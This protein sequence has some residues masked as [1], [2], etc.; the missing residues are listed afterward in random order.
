MPSRYHLTDAQVRLAHEFVSC[1]SNWRY[2]Y[3]LVR[4]T[5]LDSGTVY[6]ILARWVHEREWLERRPATLAEGGPLRFMLKPTAT[7]AV[8]FAEMVRR[9]DARHGGTS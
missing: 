5:H 3:E 8:M 1:P 6:P 2:G 7:G 4:A 9:W